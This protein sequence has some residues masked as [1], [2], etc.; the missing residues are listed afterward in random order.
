MPTPSSVQSWPPAL[1]F[2]WNALPGLLPAWAHSH[3]SFRTQLK[4]HLLCEAS[5]WPQAVLIAPFSV[6]PQ[7]FACT[8]HHF[9]HPLQFVLVSPSWTTRPPREGTMPFLGVDGWGTGTWHSAWPA[10]IVSNYSL[11]KCLYL[12]FILNFLFVLSYS[13]FSFKIGHIYV[14][15]VITLIWM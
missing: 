13:F 6:T 3:S 14:I 12:L 9:S 4:C 15:A 2:A 10:R 11:S 8:W 7:A 1:S 5:P